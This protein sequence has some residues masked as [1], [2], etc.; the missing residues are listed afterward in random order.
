MSIIHGKK[1]CENFIPKEGKLID[2]WIKLIENWEICDFIIT[3]NEI[4]IDFLLTFIFHYFSALYLKFACMELGQKDFL[5]IE[6]K[7]MLAY[8][9]TCSSLPSNS[10]IS[11]L[12]G[13]TNVFK[14]SN[15]CNII[16]SNHPV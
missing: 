7:L 6:F 13:T 11:V 14:N 1:L 9:I 2:C 5:F 3:Y 4:S 16:H 12:R 10:F 8:F 15:K